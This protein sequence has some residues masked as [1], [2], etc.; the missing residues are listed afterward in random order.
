MASSVLGRRATTAADFSEA[1]TLE[2]VDI[3]SE[4]P[5]PPTLLGLGLNRVGPRDGLYVFEEAGG[6][7]IYVQERGVPLRE[8]RDTSFDEARTAVIDELVLLNGIPF[9]V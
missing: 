7:R 9:S 1:F 2:R 6:Y 8:R 4:I 5:D 3:I